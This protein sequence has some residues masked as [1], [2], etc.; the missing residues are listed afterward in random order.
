MMGKTKSVVLAAALI[1]GAGAMLQGTANAQDERFRLERTEDGYVRMN[2]QTG[3]M[4][5]CR[6]QDGRL[7]CAPSSETDDSSQ[8]S[9]QSRL[10]DLEKRVEK[11][12]A[13]A[14]PNTGLPSEEEFDQTLGMM[15]RFFQRFIGIVK[16]LDAETDTPP[17]KPAEPE[18]GE[19]A[20][21]T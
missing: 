13:E 19:D 7:T 1:G 16:D 18:P 2:T 12:E 10:A 14:K 15:E 6:E 17:N 11:L 8:M 5:L 21:R 4:S 9:L 20:S 3:E